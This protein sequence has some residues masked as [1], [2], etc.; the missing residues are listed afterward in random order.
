MESFNWKNYLE[1]YP[2]LTHL[3]TQNEAWGHY[4][5]FGNL[6]GR[7][8]VP[9]INAYQKCNFAYTLFYNIITNYIAKCNNLKMN[10]HDS[11]FAQLLGI[12][13]FIGNTTYESNL[14]LNNENIGEVLGTTFSK[15]I[16][17]H[18]NFQIGI[19]AMYIRDYLFKLK[20][21]IININPYRARYSA[22]NDLFVHI[23]LNGICNSNNFESF[24]YYDLAISKINFETGYISSDSIHHPICTKIIRK[25]NLKILNSTTNEIKTIQFGSTCKSLVLSK[26]TFS[27]LIGV[28]GFYSKVYY[29]ERNGKIS[30]HGNIFIFKDW[31]KVNY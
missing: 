16:I 14:I 1:N 4:N 23:R 20:T 9:F 13:L 21:K 17:I 19:V 30:K 6:E 5:R 22:N 24:G 18:G 8:D 10:Y 7:T 26:S 31:N 27:W 3:K 12:D 15:N 2:D 28:F 11:T 29:P 25:Y